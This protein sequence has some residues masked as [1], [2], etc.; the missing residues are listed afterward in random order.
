MENTMGNMTT[1]CITMLSITNLFNMN[2]LKVRKKTKGLVI[3]RIIYKMIKNNDLINDLN[4]LIFTKKT[5][6]DNLLF[7]IAKETLSANI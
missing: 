3:F 1:Y 6:W 7:E 4:L 5:H 2:I